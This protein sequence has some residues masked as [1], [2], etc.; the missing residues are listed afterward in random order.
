MNIEKIKKV[1]K[2]YKI[3]LENGDEIKTYDDVIINYGL[4]YKKESIMIY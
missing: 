3:L 4:L 2:K 1:G